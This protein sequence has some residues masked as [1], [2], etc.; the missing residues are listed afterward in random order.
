[1]SVVASTLIRVKAD[2]LN[3]GNQFPAMKRIDQISLHYDWA[4]T[5]NLNWG[6]VLTDHTAVYSGPLVKFRY[7]GAMLPMIVHPEQRIS[8]PK[9]NGYRWIAIK[10]L[11]PRDIIW[12]VKGNTSLDQPLQRVRITDYDVIFVENIQLYTITTMD[13]L[14]FIAHD[15]ILHR[16]PEGYKSNDSVDMVTQ[17]HE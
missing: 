10:A 17:L 11:E 8:C 13:E 4:L 5:H 6:L 3:P 14:S 12:F 7:E 16:N 1:M 2:P 9:G 15:L